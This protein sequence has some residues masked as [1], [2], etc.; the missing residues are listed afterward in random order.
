MARLRGESR[1]EDVEGT[2]TDIA[3][4]DT[5]GLISKPTRAD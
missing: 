2:S 3:V 4:D 1:G 5:D